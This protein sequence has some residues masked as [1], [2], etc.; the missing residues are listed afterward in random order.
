[1]AKDFKLMGEAY[2]QIRKN[3]YAPAA[4]A[5]T[6]VIDEA[7]GSLGSLAGS[8]M[9]MIGAGA[10]PAQQPAPVTSAGVTGGVSDTAAPTAPAAPAAASSTKTKTDFDAA[11][12]S[13]FKAMGVTEAQ[14]KTFL[15]STHAQ[16]NGFKGQPAA[17]ATTSGTQQYLPPGKQ[18]AAPNMLAQ[19]GQ[20]E[21]NKPAWASR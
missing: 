4:E 3:L 7:G 20:R 17:T 16:L 18:P 13:Y 14:I 12:T 19:A 1:M 5:S 9:N 15:D 2:L 8:V 21:I 11:A 6:E 10:A